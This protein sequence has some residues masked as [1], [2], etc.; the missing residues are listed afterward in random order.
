MA[1]TAQTGTGA[2]SVSA[3]TGTQSGTAGLNAGAQWF[4]AEDCRLEDFIR[5]VST[6]TRREDYP[7]ASGWSAKS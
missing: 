4:H 3:V 6:E 5:T 2:P 7:F 1:I